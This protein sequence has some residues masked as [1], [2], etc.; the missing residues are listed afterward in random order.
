MLNQ[1]QLRNPPMDGR[2]NAA[3]GIDVSRDD[4]PGP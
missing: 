2:L 1:Q 4:L 3:R